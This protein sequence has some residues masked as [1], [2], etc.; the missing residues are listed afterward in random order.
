MSAVI[1]FLVFI[2]V[3]VTVFGL[4]LKSLDGIEGHMTQQE[5]DEILN[6][7]EC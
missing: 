7:E 6:S 4:V 1:A 5:I 2:V 3:L